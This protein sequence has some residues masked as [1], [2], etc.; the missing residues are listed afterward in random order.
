MFICKNCNK[1][2]TPTYF[3]S[4]TQIIH[5]CSKSC[6]AQYSRVKLNIADSFK[7]LKDRCINEIKKQNRYVPKQELVKLLKI[8]SKTLTKRKLSVILLN[9]EA[10]FK[11]PKSVF[12]DLVFKY[13]KELF[14]GVFIKQEVSF[15]SCK[16]PKGFLLK[17]DFY[18]KS[19]NLIIEADGPQH[20]NT[21]NPMYSSYVAECD[22][23]KN[24]WAVNNNINLIRIPYSRNITTKYINKFLN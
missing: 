12:Q 17:F 24:I 20:Y 19:K 6:A 4:K 14:P 1:S 5:C 23:I 22:I 10:G 15:K 8:S 11:K 7:S 13:L 9:K 21:K 18:I 16:S 2:F 3:V